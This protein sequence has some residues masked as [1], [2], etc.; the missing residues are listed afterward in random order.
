VDE[1]A[2]LGALEPVRRLVA[3]E[4]GRGGPVVGDAEGQLLVRN[5]DLGSASGHGHRAVPHGAGRDAAADADA[6]AYPLA[7]VQAPDAG[8]LD[9]TGTL[10][11]DVHGHSVARQ[12]RDRTGVHDRRLD[13]LCAGRLQQRVR[14]VGVAQGQRPSLGGGLEGEGEDV[15]GCPARLGRVG[16]REGEGDRL[17]LRVEPDLRGAEADAVLVLGAVRLVA[18]RGGE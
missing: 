5:R 14:G 2:E 10:G 18:V 17:A 1:D 13:A 7:G 15:Q 4:G 3:G 16:D 6:D 8:G 9:R 11:A 12:D